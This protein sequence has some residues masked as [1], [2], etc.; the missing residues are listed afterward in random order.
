MNSK[1]CSLLLRCAAVVAGA[2][3][4]SAPARS[5]AAT[6]GTVSCVVPNMWKQDPQVDVPGLTPTSALFEP[7]QQEPASYYAQTP[8]ITATPWTVEYRGT[9]YDRMRG[10]AKARVAALGVLWSVDPSELGMSAQQAVSALLQAGAVVARRGT[11]GTVFFRARGGEAQRIADSVSSKYRTGAARQPATAA[12]MQANTFQA[13]AGPRPGTAKLAFSSGMNTEVAML[14]LEGRMSGSPAAFIDHL[15]SGNIT[16]MPFGT[17]FVVHVPPSD[18]ELIKDFVADQGNNVLLV[19]A[20]GEAQAG[21]EVGSGIRSC[22]GNVLADRF[23]T[24]TVSSKSAGSLVV[25]V[26]G[27]ALRVNAGDTVLVVQTPAWGSGLEVAL[28]R[29]GM[30]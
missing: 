23:P 13:S 5:E 3:V 15:P 10:A 7:A 12:N 28:M 8:S 17:S 9:G 20:T 22:G 30:A 4:I 14:R 11:D 29:F 6:R 24:P 25:N 2:G 1:N 16:I 18:F 19:G 26:E 27:Q 21:A